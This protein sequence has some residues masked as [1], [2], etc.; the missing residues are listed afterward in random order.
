MR[1]PRSVTLAPMAR[2]SRSLKLAMHLR[3]LVTIGFCPV[4]GCQVTHRRI[5]SLGIIQGFAQRQY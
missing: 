3:A 4:I 2:P 5:Q 1:S